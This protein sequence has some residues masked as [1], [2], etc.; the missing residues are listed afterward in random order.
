MFPQFTHVLDVKLDENKVEKEK[1]IIEKEKPKEKEA[2]QDLIQFLSTI[3]IETLTVTPIQHVKST[4]KEKSPGSSAKG[5][6]L[7]IS[8]PSDNTPW[9]QMMAHIHDTIE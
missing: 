3:P 8:L 7:Q 5:K 4:Q 9:A 1:E 2:I 6:Q